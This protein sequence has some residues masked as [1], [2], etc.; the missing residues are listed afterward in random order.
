MHDL[1]KKTHT[2]RTSVVTTT[3]EITAEDI[4]RAFGLPGASKIRVEDLDFDDTCEKLVVEYSQS[5]Y[6]TFQGTDVS[7]EN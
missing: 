2:K 6:E 3:W 1:K 7:E 5:F 4:F